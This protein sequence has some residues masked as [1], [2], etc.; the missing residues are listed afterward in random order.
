M[1]DEDK[2]KE[3]LVNE[4][5][6]LRQQ[7][8]GRPRQAEG[9][10]EIEARYRSIYSQMSEGVCLHEIIYDEQGQ[11]VD[12]R[13]LDV[14]SSY[15]RITGLSGERAVGSKASELYGIGRPPYIETYAKVAASGQTTAFE[16]Y[17]PP[18]DKHFSI[19]VFSP[20]K[21][22]FATVFNDITEH[23]QMAE[24]LQR[25]SAILGAIN[26]IFQE[27]LECETDEEVARI[28]LAVAEELT[29]SKFGFIGEVN[30][31]GRFDT[32]ALSEPGREAYRAPEPDA[33]MMIGDM[34][35]RGLWKKVIEDGESLIVNAPL[36]HPESADVPEGHLHVNAF[37]GVPV[38][39][40]GKTIGMLALV[41]KESGYD[42]RDQEAMEALSIS[43][44][45][46]LMRERRN[47]ELTRHRE[48]LEEMVEERTRELN[49][50]MQQ[51]K[52]KTTELEQLNRTL[53]KRV[54]QAISELR[55]RDK[56]EKQRLLGEIELARKVQ[57]DLFPRSSPQV[58]GVDIWGVCHPAYEV[59]GD[60]FDYLPLG[61]DKLCLVL[62]DVS[63][64]GMEGAMNAIMA[65]GMLHAEA[66]PDSSIATIIPA[67][68]TTLR[69]CMNDVTFTTL[70][71]GI[72]DIASKELLLCNSGNPY[73][74]FLREGESSFLELSGLPLGVLSEVKYDEIKL[75][76][77]PGDVLILH[78]DG[79][80][81]ATTSD[82]QIY[83]ADRLMK[84]VG[85]LQPSMSAQDI[86][87]SILQDVK[88]FIGDS[89]QRD[90]MTIIAVRVE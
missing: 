6:E 44:A 74:I 36:S 57:T 34:E 85:T 1:S 19:S 18:M 59:G 52:E 33:A 89:P 9:S 39:Y 78:S 28:C 12:Y 20:Q 63:G 8:A 26:K 42:S 13:I 77:M 67:L 37:M 2:I 55:R 64:K 31:A 27:T 58:P 65:Y 88:A 66:R 43:F 90:D 50:M 47:E 3:Q 45:E 76:L 87:E 79:I 84:L 32:I 21:G 53:E 15:E 60:F 22:Q 38:K 16:T 80:I 68:N 70:S 72:I 25:K 4:L 73:P 69:S 82:Y 40:A 86:V 54:K 14:N 24:Q 17:F 71:L 10:S 35:I 51:L 61:Q 56:E 46:A 23:K 7:T 75:A 83:G 49:T 81:E 11:A 5:L 62:G 29:S 41:N 30:G 48:N